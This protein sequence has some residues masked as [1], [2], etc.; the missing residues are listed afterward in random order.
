MKIQR[1]AALFLLF[2]GG[3]LSAIAATPS[4]KSNAVA[5]QPD[6]PPDNPAEDTGGDPVGY[7]DGSVFVV[8]EDL[9]V[10]CPDIDL[11]FRRAYGSWSSN[12]G[13]LGYGWTHSFEW[14]LVEA[15]DRVL[16]YSA[17]E[18][19]VSDAV[20]RFDSLNPGHSHI[21][22]DGYR[23]DRS[24]DGR[25][26]V[27]TPDALTYSF[28]DRNR[29]ASISAWNGTTI[30]LE[31]QVAGR[32]SRATHSCGKWLGFEYD[33]LGHLVR[34]NTPAEGVYAE[35]AIG[36]RTLDE[37]VRH[38]GG[39]A[40]TNVYTYA[41]APSP[42]KRN[43]NAVILPRLPG[44]HSGSSN[45]YFTGSSPYEGE[46]PIGFRTGGSAGGFPPA[47]LSPIARRPPPASTGARKGND[48]AEAP[49]SPPV[50]DNALAH[51]LLSSKIDANGVEATYA[52][53]RPTDSPQFKCAHSEMDDGLFSIDLTFYGK[54]TVECRPSA[55]GLALTTHLFDGK[56]REIRRE[57]GAESLSMRYHPCGDLLEA[58]LTN[59]A[60]GFFL[61][62][63]QFCDVFHNV[64]S[65]GVGFNASPSRFIRLEWDNLRKIPRR[66]VSP[67]GRTWEWTLDGMD[68]T[69]FGA[70]TN[71]SRNVS[72]VLLNGE[73]RPVAILP[74]DGGRL[75]IA[76]DESGYATN[77]AASCLPPVSLGYDALGHVS[78]IALPG[79]DGSRRTTAVTNNWRGNPLSVAYPDGTAESFA[80]EGNGR[81]VTR[82]VDALGR[83]DVFKWVF[84]L[85]VHAGRVV[86]GA[87]NA[88]FGV[89]HDRQL[90]VVAITDPL[91]RNAETYVLDEN[92][93]AVAVTN[94]EGQT[95]SRE[96]AVGGFVS[97]VTR[98]DGTGVSY[99]YDADGNL[100]SASYPDSTLAFT[101]DRDGLLTTAANATGG[102]SNEYDAATGWLV[103][104]HGADGTTVEYAR[105]NGGDVAA[106]SSVAGTTAYAYDDAG[107]W[108]GIDSPAGTFGLGYCDWN[109][110]LAAVTNAHGLITEYTY[111]IMGRVTNIAWRTV[112]GSSLGGF[113]YAYDAAGR[114]VSR[115]HSLGGNAFDRQYAYDDLDRLVSDGGA[116][117]AYDAAGNRVSRINGGA[118]T[119]YT[120]G[121]GDRLASWTGGSYSYDAAGC[122][123]RI[124]RTG[125]P[126]L[127]LDW[128]GQYQ[129][130]SVKR[131]GVLLESYS[132][133]ALGRRAST[134]SAGGTIRHV[135]DDNWQCI[136][137]ID[138]QDNVVASYVWGEGID[139]LLAVKIGET[140]YYALTDVQGTVWGYVDSSNSVVA[141]WLYDAWGNVLD[142]SVSV[143]ALATIRYRFQGREWS[144]ATGLV[145]FR[146]RWYDPDT[147]R[148]L[149][150]DPIRLGGGLNQYAFCDVN[151][152][153]Y[154]D[155]L[156]LFPKDYYMETTRGVCLNGDKVVN[157][158]MKF[159]DAI[160]IASKK[161]AWVPKG[162]TSYIALFSLSGGPWGPCDFKCNEDRVIFFRNRFWYQD[163][164]GNYL[165]GFQ[166][167]YANV[168]GL[169]TG[170]KLG[171]WLWSA[172]PGDEPIGDSESIPMIDEGFRDGQ[173][174]RIGKNRK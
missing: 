108:T 117:Y 36:N 139:N 73:E 80:Y 56:R 166:A 12:N 141:R 39:S 172:I 26:S 153:N 169:L 137:D 113:A 42:G 50:A 45:H 99:G 104:S 133:D 62:A 81:R 55:W 84:G 2:T 144:A 124:Q 142:E 60:T 77:F 102:V 65:A 92:E 74:P 41:E 125:R 111:D 44:F 100:A 33:V 61:E 152:V 25:Y 163:E 17:G 78:S 7:E 131:N 135:Y 38:D 121:I 29:L 16:V 15:G 93:R 116:T 59:S 53:V 63:G 23:L 8:E 6:A 110:S 162:F 47:C 174:S 58:V 10:A 94:V 154:K 151:T 103:S 35:F 123:T 66:V 171:G 143:P 173:R 40:S 11:A 32:L 134:T 160:E 159:Y 167:G 132:Y 3:L 82:H 157:D 9:R 96:Y 161:H 18:R 20:H 19:G 95:M 48:A 27:L 146:M 130:T 168:R 68:V 69:I 72:H 83:E 14:R 31:R 64:V 101:Y 170:V 145:N 107:R 79:P 88:L 90:N 120:L 115:N 112:G 21:N 156:G 70:G 126:M 128:N 34:V 158:I 148:W 140:T 106:V 52:Y 150:K 30:S 37:V 71:D 51:P 122:V 138:E 75:D 13:S 136:A 164:F 109:G 129:L 98:F 89:E 28:D 165:A 105:R 119:S 4:S 1:T 67:A 85:P 97:S 118:T 5:V 46:F 22:P 57:T 147:G 155:Q 43:M 54:T 24:E 76:Y 91:G 149:S 127:D 49:I 87:T 114:I 86:N